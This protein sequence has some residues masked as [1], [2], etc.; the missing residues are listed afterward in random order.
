VLTANL[1]VKTRSGKLS[2]AS[3]CPKHWNLIITV[4]FL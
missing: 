4:K 2:S 3:E 1:L